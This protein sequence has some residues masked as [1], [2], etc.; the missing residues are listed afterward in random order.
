MMGDG[1]EFEAMRRATIT[2]PKF[3]LDWGVRFDKY[4]ITEPI[5]TPSELIPTLPFAYKEVTASEA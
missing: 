4:D 1:M 2:A 5:T 3:G